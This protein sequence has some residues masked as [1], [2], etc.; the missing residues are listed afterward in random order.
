LPLVKGFIYLS[1]VQHIPPAFAHSNNENGVFKIKFP[2]ILQSLVEKQSIP[3]LNVFLG[4][5]KK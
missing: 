4:Q 1:L 2:L 5:P 3:T